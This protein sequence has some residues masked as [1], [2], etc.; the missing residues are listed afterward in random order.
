MPRVIEVS[1]L[2]PPRVE[3]DGGLVSFDTRKAMALLAHLAV[4]ERPRPRDSL[5]DLLWPGSDPERARGAL[6]RTLS[7]LRSA[8]GHELLEATRDHVRLI[9]GPGLAIDVALFRSS[10]ESSR[11][12]E[13]VALFRGDFL[14]GFAVRDAPDFEDWAQIEADI[15]RRELVAALA[16][17]AMTRE[18]AGDRMGALDAVRRWVTVDPLHEPAHRALIRLYAESGDRAAALIQYRECVRTLS[19][20]L[21]VP[22][23]TETTEL[24]EA[25]NRGVYL[26]PAPPPVQA[27]A[28]A[29]ASPDLVGRS[30]ELA[31]LRSAYDSLGPDGGVVRIEGEAGI[32]K[33]R[34][35]EE[36]LATLRADGAQVLVGR[37]FEDETGLAYGPVA[38]ALLV[39]LREGDAWLSG[40]DD[41]TLGEAARL[42][43]D[44]LTEVVPTI[45]SP[46]GG[47]GAETRFL[48]GLW[49]T[50]VSAAEGPRPG[51]LFLDDAQWADDAT[52]TLL[53]YGLRR[54]T[55]RPLLLLMTGRTPYDHA[56]RRAASAAALGGRG[57]L[58]HLERLPETAVAE[59]VRAARPEEEGAELV[60]RL[61]EKTEGVPL[62]LVEYLRTLDEEG[63]WVLPSGARE[64][65]LTRL[66]P[67]TE[68]ARQTLSAAAVIGR[69]FDTDA[70]R[71]VSGRT[72]D[73]TVTSLEELVG[74]G[75][76]REGSFDYDFGHGL[77]RALVYEE[78]SLARR[79]LLHGRAADL[80]ATAL[81]STARHLM[82]AGRERD[83]AEAFRMAGELAR[84]LFANTDA[85]AHLRAALALGHPRV[86]QL[87]M[88]VGDLLTLTGD[89]AAAQI[90]LE[91]AAANSGAN[92]LAEVEHHLGRLHHRRGDFTLAQAHL[93]AALDAAPQSRPADRASITA[94]LSLAAHAIDDPVRARSLATQAHVLAQ[95]AH[96]LRAL[97]QSYNLLGMLATADGDTD[98]ALSILERSRD[99]ADQVGAPD[100]QVAALNNLALARRAR[101][102]L[103][104]AVDLTTA[105][106]DLCSATSADRHHEAALHNNLA[107]LLHASGRSDESMVHLKRA[108]E[109]FAEVGVETEPRPGIWKLV[110]W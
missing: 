106:L 74:R 11:L 10:R 83:A 24:Y 43:P 49:G 71:L 28:E 62:F 69:S 3:R 56:L 103:E 29:P 19:R 54:L 51:V 57:T 33:T 94:D 17:L 7:S 4:T 5:A 105:A 42:L 15:L 77:V 25:I 52:L 79:R 68:T 65:L 101:D 99:L 91:A 92:E 82:L 97:C 107:D 50:L 20:E 98:E 104:A 66:G 21:G 73:E 14:E 78:T 37:A 39:R 110:R 59:M 95:E 26:A 40:V 45:A 87:Q 48:S 80:P 67:L 23:L 72:E 22:P 89:Y 64:L 13:A 36:F 44:L 35:A 41:R 61:W 38:E 9:R 93:H 12:E 8:I 55:G 76:L 84:Q 31:A 6:R 32:G 109:I 86:A 70:V 53:S 60:H 85:L 90:S 58:V 34:L 100:L 47:P 30:L 108:V 102:E 63:E 18:T 16:E 27:S 88:A 75:L 96:D 46:A 2:G 1:L 81:A